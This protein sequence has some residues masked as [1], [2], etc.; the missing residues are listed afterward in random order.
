[1]GHGGGSHERNARCVP[2]GSHGRAV[3]EAG[4]SAAGHEAGEEGTGVADAASGLAGGSGGGGGKVGGSG[5]CGRTGH[6]EWGLASLSP[7][8]LCGAG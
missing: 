8:G 6:D 3:C 7:P 5:S 1:M 4:R 2:G